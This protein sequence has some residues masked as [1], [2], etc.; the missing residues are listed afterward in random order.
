MGSTSLSWHE[1]LHEAASAVRERIR[2]LLPQRGTRPFPAFKDLLDR[3]AHEAILETLR[4]RALSV[5]LV[6][7]EGEETLGA[8]EFTVT[9]DP[10]DGTTNL[11]RGLPPSVVSMSAARGAHQSEVFAALVSDL[12]G[13]SSYWADPVRG[14]LRDGRPIRVAAPVSYGEGLVSMDVSKMADLSAVAPLITR[15]RHIRS[16]GCAASSLCRVA[17]GVL[18]AHVDERGT[19][20]GTDVSAGLFILGQAG[21]AWTVDGSP[22]GGFPLLRE[23][24]IRLTAASG[25]ELLEEIAA[26]RSR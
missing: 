12:I 15:A 1:V 19:I 9:A 23:T 4:R 3:N 6:S 24:R 25:T 20:R 26:C 7:E 2:R 22:F 18:D 17:E 10:V 21:G 5:R 8:G 13:G 16:A 14:A 11:A